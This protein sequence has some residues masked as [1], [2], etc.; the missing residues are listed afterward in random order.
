MIPVIDIF[1]GP[2]GLAEGFSSLQRRDGK[3]CFDI[4]LSIECE[5]YAFSTLRLRSF[6]RQFPIGEVPDDYYSF[7]RGHMRLEDLF[8]SWPV[9][10]GKAAAETLQAKLGSDNHVEVDERIRA[11]LGGDTRWVLI[12]GPPCQAYSNAGMVGNRTRAEYSPEKDERYYLYREY[13]RIV[14]T[15]APA[16]FVLENVPGMLAAKLQGKRIIRDVL[17]GL[18][19]PGPFTSST[20]GLRTEA[21]GYS[22]YS[23]VEGA[24]G[25]DDDPRHFIVKSETLGIP[26]TRHRVI[27]VGVREDIDAGGLRQLERAAPTPAGAVL[28][29]LPALRSRLSKEKDSLESW[30]GVFGPL[31]RQPWLAG[32]RSR[33]GNQLVDTIVERATSIITDSPEETGQEF[34]PGD[35]KTAWN[36]GWY[37][38]SRLGGCLHH[39]ARPQIRGDLWRYLF[40]SCY[41][42]AYGSPP[43]LKDF[44]AELLPAHRNAHSGDF[45]DRFRTVSPRQPSGTVISHLAKDGHAFIHP[46]PVQCRSLTPREAARLQTFPDN[47][48]FFGGRAAQFRQIGN[49]VP[50]VLA[51]K[52]GELLLHLSLST[53][54]EGGGLS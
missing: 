45:K 13:I 39:Q 3:R 12:G 4:R 27:I 6:Y 30:R 22:L 14:A 41:T 52:L 1:A 32:L 15:H 28:C 23:V 16:A 47:Y 11:A 53:C 8:A 46:D 21:P 51:R 49:A 48:Y 7:A 50:P 37:Y 5:D 10:A 43:V 36:T 38:D 17:N 18:V 25:P 2:G 40:S 20:F 9:A 54:P 33:Y 34:I 35:Y 19:A 29:G 24:T 31:A 42:E 44:P 26:Q